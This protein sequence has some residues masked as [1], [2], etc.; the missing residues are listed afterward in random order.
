[1]AWKAASPVAFDTVFTSSLRGGCVQAAI[2]KA[3]T[4]TVFFIGFA[5][6]QNPFH[7]GAVNVRQPEV[8]PLEFVRQPGVVDAQT[9]QDGRVQVVDVDRIACDVVTEIVRLADGNARLDAAAGQPD[10]KAA[11]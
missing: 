11:R 5:L 8:T 1:M 6:R 4:R 3:T 7:E 10:G 2:R 9:M